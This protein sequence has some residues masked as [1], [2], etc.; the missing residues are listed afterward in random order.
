LGLGM[1]SVEQLYRRALFNIMAR[2]QDDHVKNI[3]FLMDSS[4]TWQLSPAFD[5]TFAY[6]PDGDFTSKHQMSLNGKRDDFV[7]QDFMAI[8]SRFSIPNGR[9]N[10]MIEEVAQGVRNWEVHAQEAGV[11]GARIESRQRLHRVY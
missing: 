7:R 1:A 2:N 3:A 10:S 6:N 9:A 8:A 5:L 4:G 11:S